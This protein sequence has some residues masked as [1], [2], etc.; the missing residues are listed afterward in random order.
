M[1]VVQNRITC[2]VEVSGRV[3]QGFAHSTEGMKSNKGFVSFNLLK[4][5]NEVEAGKVLYVAMT[6]WED[7][8]SFQTWR[9]GD[10][11]AK[12]HSSRASGEKSPLQSTVEVFEV[13]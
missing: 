7:R 10:S 8:E 3:E 11:F 1:I 6:F 5:E 13:V 2:P 12:A 9:E 4:L